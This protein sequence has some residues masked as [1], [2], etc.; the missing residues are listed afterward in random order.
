MLENALSDDP[1]I[2]GFMVLANE[3]DD[4]AASDPFLS[5]ESSSNRTSPVA[6]GKDDALRHAALK[7][8]AKAAGG[9]DKLRLQEV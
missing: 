8:V 3:S 2:E 4:A 1:N 6:D 7:V 5:D 9:L